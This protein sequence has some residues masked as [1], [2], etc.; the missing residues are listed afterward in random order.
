MARAVLYWAPMKKTK[1]VGTGPAK[2]TK[3]DLLVSIEKVRDLDQ[4]TGGVGCP[5]SIKTADVCS[6]SY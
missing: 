4:V 2:K 1:K 5:N 6:P 3:K